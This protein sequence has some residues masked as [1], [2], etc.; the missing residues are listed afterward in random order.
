MSEPC[1]GICI[2]L[3]VYLDSAEFQKRQDLGK[4]P[5]R[6]A[7]LIVKGIADKI[8]GKLRSPLRQ[9]HVS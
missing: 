8:P 3:Y 2:R 4:G 7:T 5:C 9:V 1:W 6:Y